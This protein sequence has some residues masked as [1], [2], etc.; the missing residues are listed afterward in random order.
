[1]KRLLFVARKLWA[2]R[3]IGVVRLWRGAF[4]FQLPQQLRLW[5]EARVIK[6]FKLFDEPWYRA[7][8]PEVDRTGVDALEHFVAAGAAA[9]HDPNPLFGTTWYRKRY[10][11]VD[12]S[13]LN[14]LVHY[15]LWG[16]ALGYDPH[17]Y[18]ETLAYLQRHPDVVGTVNPLA[19]FLN[20]RSSEAVRLASDFEGGR[21]PS[22]NDGAEPFRGYFDA[23]DCVDGILS[24][25][26]WMCALA[27]PIQEFKLA[28]NGTTLGSIEP[29]ERQ[30]V[31]QLLPFP[32]ATRP[33]FRFE[34]KLPATITER[35]L[36]V[37]IV[38]VANDQE[39]SRLSTLHWPNY[40]DGWPEPPPHLMMRTISSNSAVFYWN[41][42]LQSFSEYLRHIER[43]SNVS[44]PKRLLDW[45]CGCGRLTRF[46]LAQFPNLEVH[47][48]DIDSEQI[49]WCNA[50]L[51]T[52]QFIVV[53]PAPPA[54]FADGMF[55]IV[56]SW[57]VLTHLSRATQLEWLKEMRRILARGGLFVASVS[58]ESLSKF[59][60]VDARLTMLDDGIA[61]SSL[62]PALDGIAPVGY[63]RGTLQGRNYTCREF[64]RY[65]EIVDYI[66]Q[67]AT[68]SQDLV[69]MRRT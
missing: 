43:H 3:E 23:V 11:D 7:R 33:G 38:G 47:G 55:D 4:T 50:H 32:G 59:Y 18:F 6:R 9:G 21:L 30:D 22:W 65:F 26:G 10:P 67:G 36:A 1:M 39:V 24:V 14:P 45:G 19:H 44:A 53:P 29:S 2:V 42:G 16:A 35:R 13:G 15:A 64:S 31:S 51:T 37:E 27:F 20:S 28:V 57:S 12:E 56:V 52:G 54:P 41:V 40:R 62:D 46:F 66:R 5:L 34:V 25:S 68:S 58:G 60:P 48:C 49:D 17:P 63:Y 69:V 61:D 8:Y